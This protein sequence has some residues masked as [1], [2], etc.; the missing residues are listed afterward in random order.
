MP[1]GEVNKMVASVDGEYRMAKIEADAYFEKQSRIARAIQA[2]AVAEAAS[3]REMNRALVGTGGETLVKLRI[4]EALQDKK[5]ILL[6]VSEGGMN[7]KTTDM[8]RLIE[9]MGIKSLAQ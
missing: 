1:G 6:P 5:I 7:L 8:N 4:A 2:E 9:M 3:I